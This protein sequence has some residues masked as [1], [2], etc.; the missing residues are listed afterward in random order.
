MAS[1]GAVDAE[2]V[3]QRRLEKRLES[4]AIVKQTPKYLSYSSSIPRASRSDGEPRT[5]SPGG[6]S[7]SVR[8][9]RYRIKVWRQSL[10]DWDVGMSALE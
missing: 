3:Y 8:Q 7:T 5:P 1:E 4:I 6:R 2:S 10:H 9:F